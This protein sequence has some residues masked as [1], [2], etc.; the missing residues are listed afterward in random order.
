MF[1]ASV[2]D[3]AL[4]NTQMKIGEQIG[5][6]LVRRLLEIIQELKDLMISKEPPA[7]F[8]KWKEF[9]KQKDYANIKQY[10]EKEHN[11]FTTFHNTILGKIIS[12]NSI[13]T[14]TEDI[15]EL[16]QNQNL[17]VNKIFVKK[18]K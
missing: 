17:K 3:D 4:G 15:R 1:L 6:L 5:Y 7:G 9:T 10:I 12:K 13:K 2:A 18:L 11:L 8:D 16:I 14:Y